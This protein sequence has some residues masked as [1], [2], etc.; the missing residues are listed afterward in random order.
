MELISQHRT[1][2]YLS[3]RF[4]DGISSGLF[5][6]ALSWLLLEPGNMGTFVA[7]L[8][9][10][11]TA[12]SFVLSP[13]FATLI[14]RHSRKA[15]LIWVQVLQSATAGL[16]MIAAMFNLDSH[17]LLGTSQLIFWVSSNLAWSTNNAFTQEN[18]DSHEYASISG[19]QEIVLQS[20][21]LGAG[22]LGVVLLK[23]WGMMEF[24][25]FAASASAIAAVSYLVTPY[26]QQLREQHTVRFISQ[27]LQSKAI[28]SAQ[29]R[30]Y[31]L[32]LLSCLSYPVLTFLSKL[33]P[34]WF[35]ELGISGDWFAA[36]SIL[37]GLGSLLTGALLSKLL[38][39]TSHRVTLVYSMAMLAVVLIVIALVLSPLYLLLL[40]VL[41]GF[42]NALNRI[43]RTNWL[44]H[45]VDVSQRGR[46]EGGLVLFSTSVQSISYVVIALLSHYG[47][48]H[49]GFAIAA[50]TV[51]AAA[52][53][54]YLL[55]HVS[56]LKQTITT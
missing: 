20:T 32:I 19:K 8:A 33:V 10:I 50:L 5:M 14:D 34:I 42:F 35:A 55:G 11:C 41:L 51:S 40:T 38:A 3:G 6:M 15:I 48:T 39:L 24:A 54:M 9:L 26:R 47:L 49:Y 30:F 17:W 52:I 25:A 16:V 21:T 45:T 27:M 1:L 36:Y 13:F 44:H 18:Y 12:T 37:F 7:V 4:F 29:P 2:P 31:T 23:Y 43:T 22:A 46:V 28:F 53:M 56:Q